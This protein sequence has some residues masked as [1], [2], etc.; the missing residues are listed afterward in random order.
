[1]SQKRLVIYCAATTLVDNQ[2]VYAKPLTDVEGESWGCPLQPVALR[3][4]S[5]KTNDRSSGDNCPDA[6]AKPNNKLSLLDM[7]I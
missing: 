2:S 7:V 4:Q 3:V 5:P 1:M 6:V